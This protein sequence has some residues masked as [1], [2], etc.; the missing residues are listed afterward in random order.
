M[1][2]QA[3]AFAFLFPG[4]AMTN[5]ILA[6]AYISIFPNLLL[7]FVPPDINTGSLN[8][9]VSFAVGGLLGDVFLHLLPHAFL[10]EHTEENAVV[11]VDNKKNVLI[12]VGIFVGLFFFFFMDKMMRVVNGGSGH[13][14]GHIHT[15]STA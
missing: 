5:S 12:G 10:G 13:D 3:S 6:T 1:S 14:H 4:N 7:Y 11:V 8:T 15:E 2:F 9:L